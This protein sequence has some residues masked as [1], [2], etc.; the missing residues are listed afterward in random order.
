MRSSHRSGSVSA[1]FDDGNLIGYG[2]LEP[3]MRLAQRCGLADLVDEHLQ[4]RGAAN[5]GG[6]NPA[7][8]VTSLVAGMLAGSS[9]IDGIGRLRHG[10]MKLLFNGVRAPSTAGT[11]LRSFTHGHNR[12]LH[13]VHRR[14]LASLAA[15]VTLLPD[16]ADLTLVDIDPSH[17]RVYGANKQEPHGPW[18]GRP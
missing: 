18:R 10:G 5:S 1:V 16:A 13:T 12:Q 3:A 2:G 14:F 6:A 8:K 7:A 4:I 9:T 15:A 17:I 11:F